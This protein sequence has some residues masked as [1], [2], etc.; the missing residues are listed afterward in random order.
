MFTL[1]RG[2]DVYAPEPLGR[3]DV[4]LCGGQIILV[5]RHIDLPKTLDVQVVE[6]EG[7]Y[8]VPGLIDSHVH[9]IGGGGEGGPATRTPELRITQ[10]VRAGITTV[11]G[12]IGTDGTTR[13]A[14]ELVTKARGL[15]AE[16]ISCYCHVG[17]YHIPVRTITGAIEDDMLL[18]DRII[19]VG[20]VAI[21]D[22]RS[23][24]PTKEELAKV[25]SQARIGGMLSGKAGIVNVHIGAG[26]SRLD[27]LFEVADTTE[28]PLTSFC[29]T[30]V[31]RTEK[32]FQA[33]LTFAEK[34][35]VIDF[36]TST[37]P[38]FLEDGEVNAPQAVRRA[39]EAGVNENLLTMTSDGQGSLP[40]FNAKGELI[41]MT[42]A[43]VGSLH[44]ALQAAIVEEGVAP[45]QALKTVTQNPASVL[46]LH[47]KGRIAAGMDGDV[48]LLD[49]DWN[50][51][52]L[53]AKGK[54]MM[55]NKEML[56]KD[57]FG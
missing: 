15:E 29:P 13:T 8:L 9:I 48:L 17:N 27:L 10:A 39:L 7:K 6:A 47:Q 16:G 19:G 20:E 21:S 26:E 31:N 51:D 55:E 4:L 49:G 5:K 38:Q 41:G 23:S 40:D 36:T 35:G 24:Q 43:D 34:G 54:C 18:I 56:T 2:A 25:A 33:G 30:H 22:H 14:A 12:V 42:A 57:T 52:S 53:W 11:I 3:K 50:V 32:L 1:I 45:E 44:R 37:I 46:K 28:L